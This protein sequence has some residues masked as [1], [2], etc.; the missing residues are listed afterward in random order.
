MKKFLLISTLLCIALTIHAQDITGSWQGSLPANGKEVRLIFHIT[1]SPNNYSATFDSP[2]QNAY[3][4]A[5]SSTTVEKDSLLIG[6][7]LIKGSY[8]GK[9]DGADEIKGIYSQNGG[10]T[11]MIMKRLPKTGLPKNPATEPKPQTPKPPFS[12]TSEEVVF[13]NSSQKVQ[14]AG[15]FTKPANGTK[16]PVVLL[17]TGSGA[18]DRDERIGM[19][20]PFFLFADHLAKQGIAVLR[21]DDR[22]VG[23]STG[24]FMKATSADF[25]T[26]VMAGIAYLKTR[27]DIDPKKIGLMGHSEGGMIA[28]YVA[29]RSKDVAF[30]VMLAGPV[31]VGK[32]TMY[33][34]AVEQPLAD[35]T[36]YTRKA[37]GEFYK[38]MLAIALDSTRNKNMDTSVRNAYFKWKKQTPDSTFKI[39]FPATDEEL[40]IQALTVGFSDLKRPWW[41]FFLT[42][43]PKKDVSSLQIPVLALN[44]EKDK[45]VD[46]K[47]NLALINELLTKN[48]NKHFKTYEVPGVNHLFQ[49]CKECGSVN[50][51]LALEETF[52]STTLN[53]ISD[54]IKIQVK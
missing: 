52:D 36:A 40:T 19:H 7:Q 1:G 17:I 20:K 18:Q 25:A 47:A 54:W 53:M 23:K 12:Y 21:V 11:S 2:D 8:H 39:L 32:K 38:S 28:P 14:L 24:D 5:C 3:G 9:W 22:G 4:L 33:F 43:D 48:G 41:Q 31:V 6:I 46:P 34:Q 51:Y 44:G 27:N 49:H 30:I 29:A 45:Q 15:T 26:D 35:E 16:F 13:E 50:E 37:Y 42:Y 10:S